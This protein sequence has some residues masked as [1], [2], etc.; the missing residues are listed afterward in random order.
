MIAMAAISNTRSLQ[1]G[2]GEGRSVVI[3]LSFVILSTFSV[4]LRISTA[5]GIFNDTCSSAESEL[6]PTLLVEPMS[7]IDWIM[8]SPS[9]LSS[10]LSWET[11][12]SMFSCASLVLVCIN[13]NGEVTA[14]AP[15]VS[16]PLLTIPSEL[17]ESFIS[18][19]ASKL[20]WAMPLTLLLSSSSGTAVCPPGENKDVQK[21]L[22]GMLVSP[23]D[24]KPELKPSL[25]DEVEV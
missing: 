2:I 14:C 4:T 13:C 20:D 16:F 7:S 8:P 10:S 21:H 1:D 23:G 22:E 9:P 12:S 24:I 17:M 18:R 19:S 3:K 25:G 6:A 11:T 15:D 5:L